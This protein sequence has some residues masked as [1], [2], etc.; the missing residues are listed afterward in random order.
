[1]IKTCRHCNTEFEAEFYQVVSCGPC[2]SEQAKQR[3]AQAATKNKS[4][5]LKLGKYASTTR[6]IMTDAEQKKIDAAV[7]AKFHVPPDPGRRLEGEEFERIKKLYEST[8][9]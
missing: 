9:R 2:R 3:H 6:A 4:P 7:A 5:Y 1:M 8:R